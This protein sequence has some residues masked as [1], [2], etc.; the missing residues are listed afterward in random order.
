[1]EIFFETVQ[2]EEVGELEGADVAATG[3]DFTL[4]VDND[5]ADV[6]GRVAGLE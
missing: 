3:T 5:V 4:E 2:L 1:L 6:L